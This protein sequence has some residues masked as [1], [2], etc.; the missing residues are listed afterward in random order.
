MT[1]PDETDQDAVSLLSPLA[2]GPSGPSRIDVARAMAEGGRRRRTRWWAGGLAAVALT[3]AGSTLAFS[4]SGPPAPVR[5]VLN[6]SAPVPVPTD[7][8]VTRLTVPETEAALITGS[9]SSGRWQVGRAF[10]PD[11]RARLVV[12]HDGAVV[13]GI[14]TADRA[15]F[16]DINA[17]GEAVGG[18]SV[19]GRQ[20]SAYLGGR[21]SILAG[22]EGVAKAIN[23]AGVVV[24]ALGPARRVKPVRW[25]SSTAEPTQ[26]PLPAGAQYGT[27]VDVDESGT[28]VGKVTVDSDPEA[29]G[30]LTLTPVTGYLWLADGTG[31]PFPL[32]DV[33]GRAADGFESVAIR[34]GWVIGL[35]IVKTRTGTD[36]RPFRYNIGTGRYERLGLLPGGVAAN[37]SV[38]GEGRQPAI[39]NADGLT[40][41]LPK[42]SNPPTGASYRLAGISDDGLTTA[43]GTFGGP[44]R[45]SPLLWRC[46]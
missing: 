24:G 6:P 39:I 10:L 19:T 3:A 20:P 45:V 17:R 13:A 18:A 40:T 43:G 26:L 8:T 31:R 36:F 41:P 30:P 14:G 23:D 32:P 5:P 29:E 25:Q 22:G 2:G 11:N 28:V 44:T 34:N 33:D 4:A 1:R 9:D 37:G 12:W 46:R 38:A 16:P 7:C 42:G 21:M 35:G 15:D 27:A